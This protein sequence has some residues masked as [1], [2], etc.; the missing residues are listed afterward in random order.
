MTYCLTAAYRSDWPLQSE[1]VSFKHILDRRALN[2][3]IP[4]YPNHARSYFCPLQLLT[5]LCPTSFK[6]CICWCTQNRA[7]PEGRC[8]D[9]LLNE[10][11]YT[12]HLWNFLR[13][14]HPLLRLRFGIATI[15]FYHSFFRAFNKISRS[16]VRFTKWNCTV[17]YIYIY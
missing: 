16:R 1:H 10:V 3:P 11:S 12:R 6:I 2:I 7:T 14:P 4:W 5:A 9:L 13:A 8:S 17:L 15:L